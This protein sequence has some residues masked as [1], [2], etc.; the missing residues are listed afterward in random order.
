MNRGRTLVNSDHLPDHC[1][2]PYWLIG[3]CEGDSSFFF[4]KSYLYPRFSITQNNK[5]IKIMKLIS[6]FFLNL[7]VILPKSILSVEGILNENL[8]L[9]NFKLSNN[10]FLIKNRN[11]IDFSISRID[12]LFYQVLPFFENYKFFSRKGLDFQ[13]WSILLKLRYLGYHNVGSIKTVMLE[14]P[15]NMNNARYLNKNYMLQTCELIDK[16]NK[17]I[18]TFPFLNK[19][20]KLV[21]P[22][23][24]TVKESIIENYPQKKRNLCLR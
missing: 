3:F 2:N 18:N 15:E 13:I 21:K 5:S 4:T 16:I 8:N 9:K 12:I 7:P 19:D 23:T 11:K 14:L 22:L 6:H 1:L 17:F 10:D 20:F 24:I